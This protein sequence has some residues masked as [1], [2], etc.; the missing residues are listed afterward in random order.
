MTVA[1]SPDLTDALCGLLDAFVAHQPGRVPLASAVRYTEIAQELDIGDGMWG[2]LTG[3]AG[4]GAEDAAE[5][6]GYRIEFVDE[7]SGEAVFF[8]A[9]QERSAPGM[10]MLRMKR[11]EG[12]I[13]EIEAL[14]VRE[15]IVGEH[16]GTVSLFQPR[17]LIPF[18]PTGFAE[19][20]PA[21]VAPIA[22][23]ADPETLTDIVDAYFDAIEQDDPGQ[24]RF[25]DGCVV[26]VNGVRAAD[27]PELGPLNPDLPDYRPFA[28]GPREQIETG[29]TRYTSRIRH[30][31]HVA[32]DP[33]RGLVLSVAVFDHAAR[34]R[35]I[36]VPDIGAVPLPGYVAGD[37]ETSIAALPG[38]KIFPNLQVPTSDLTAQLTR[39]ENGE[40][41]YVETISR[42]APYG[43]PTGW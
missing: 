23:P 43:L 7:A 16:G 27:N 32:V 3:F 22:E 4:D 30:R 11:I 19:A 20:D 26:R 21:L 9:T 33:T 10:T 25:A 35:E 6:N 2:T 14:A 15:E 34:V 17:P 37:E 8:G 36:E 29:F 18:D 39:I 13:T 31:R 24:A 40:I 38:S 41:V 42:G 5:R 28:L 1:D 12:E